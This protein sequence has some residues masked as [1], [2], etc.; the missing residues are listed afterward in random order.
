MKA[1]IQF[2]GKSAVIEL[3]SDQLAQAKKQTSHFT[4]IKTLQD[5]LDYVGET[6]DHFNHR[7]Q[8]DDDGQRQGKNLRL[9]Y[10]LF[11]KAIL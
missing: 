9:S 4:N 7:T 1:T 3:T 5:A 10:W 2:N 8:F 11:V 6:I